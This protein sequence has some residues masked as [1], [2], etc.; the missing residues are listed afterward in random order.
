MKVSRD[1]LNHV[2]DGILLTAGIYMLVWSIL[3]KRY[4]LVYA[5]AAIILFLVGAGIWAY[6]VDKKKDTSD[7]N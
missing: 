7:D 6:I 3:E 5:L 4:G 1:M 2:K